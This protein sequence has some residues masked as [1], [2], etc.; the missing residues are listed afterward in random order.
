MQIALL[1]LTF[2]EPQSYTLQTIHLFGHHESLYG[3]ASKDVK[4]ED[5]SMSDVFWQWG[6]LPRSQACYDLRVR[7]AHCQVANWGREV[8]LVMVV[9]E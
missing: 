2:P 6:Y 7:V 9:A 8:A 3:Q 1:T 5:G 4:Q